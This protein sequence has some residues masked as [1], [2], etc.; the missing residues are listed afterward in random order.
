MRSAAS[1]NIVIRSTLIR[2]T[3]NKVSNGIETA[4]ED[5][6]QIQRSFTHNYSSGYSCGRGLDPPSTTTVTSY[7]CS[8]RMTLTLI[9]VLSVG[10]ASNP[11]E[12]NHGGGS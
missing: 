8:C 12:T 6:H 10:D 7:S 2:S 9:I 4:L 3:V 1:T 11:G 5:N